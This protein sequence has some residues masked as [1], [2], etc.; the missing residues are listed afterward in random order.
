MRLNYH[1]RCAR[2]RQDFRVEARAQNHVDRHRPR[3]ALIVVLSARRQKRCSPK[4]GIAA[5]AS[6]R[7]ALEF[8]REKPS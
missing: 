2:C 8:Y 6:W 7:R 3:A 1:W 4:G 5:P